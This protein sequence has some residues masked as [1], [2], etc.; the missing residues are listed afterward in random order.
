MAKRRKL[1]KRL[2]KGARRVLGSD[3]VHEVIEDLVSAALIAAAVKL[4]DSA[5][6]QRAA[7]AAIDKAGEVAAAAERTVAGKPKRRPR[8]KAAPRKA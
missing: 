7:A 3:I 1:A 6:V 2:R 4:R 5:S 8:K